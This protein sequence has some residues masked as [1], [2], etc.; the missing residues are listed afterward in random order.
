[1]DN[2]VIARSLRFAVVVAL[3]DTTINKEAMPL[4]KSYFIVQT[5]IDWK[6]IS[7]LDGHLYEIHEFKIYKYVPNLLG[8]FN[9]DRQ[10]RI[11]CLKKRLQLNNSLHKFTLF[12][13]FL[14]LNLIKDQFTKCFFWPFYM[15]ITK[16][17]TRASYLIEL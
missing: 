9:F 8:I 6:V 4:G 12:S 5:V 7:T 14:F 13:G 16:S 15:T 17:K 1:M 10:T 11:L 3:K 2:K